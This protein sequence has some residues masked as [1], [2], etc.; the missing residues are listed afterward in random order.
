MESFIGT[1]EA[2][3]KLNVSVRRVQALIAVGRLP[4]RKI[5]NAFAISE[6]DLAR[7]KA[8]KSGRP[9]PV[10]ER[11]QTEWERIVKKYVG[12]VDVGPEDLST[13]KKYL[14]RLGRDKFYTP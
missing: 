6:R 2:A 4:A 13:N 5:G 1:K 14:E 10:H 3:E 11:T 8:R 12:C 7:V 9:K